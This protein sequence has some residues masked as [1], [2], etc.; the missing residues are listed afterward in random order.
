MKTQHQSLGRLLS[1]ESAMLAPLSIRT[2]TSLS[3]HKH[4]RQKVCSMRGWVSVSACAFLTC[5]KYGKGWPKSRLSLVSA[6]CHPRHFRSTVYGTIYLKQP[7]SEDEMYLKRWVR[8]CHFV[9]RAVSLR[10]G[11][12]HLHLGAMFLLNVSFPN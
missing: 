11:S 12:H 5:V 2:K 6:R 7:Y 3:F 4:L 10:L 9:G 8:D 1:G